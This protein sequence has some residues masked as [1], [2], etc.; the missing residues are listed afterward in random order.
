MATADTRLQSFRLDG[1]CGFFSVGQ[2][3]F[4][5]ASLLKFKPRASAFRLQVV[6]FR[7]EGLGHA[8]LAGGVGGIIGNGIFYP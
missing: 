6:G 3:Q 4:C 1:L 5:R 8:S 7:V 2:V